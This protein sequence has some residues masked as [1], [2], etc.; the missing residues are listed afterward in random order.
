MS[1]VKLNLLDAD[2]ILSGTIHGSMTDRCVAALSAEP[3]T[4][5]ELAAALARYVR[6]AD[7][8]S[9]FVSFCAQ[10]EVD[11][12]PWDAGLVIID[13]AA[14]VISAES[15]YSQPSP[16]GEVRYHDGSKCTD[17]SIPYRVP[18]DWLFVNSFEAF[19]W[20][21]ERRRIE[22]KANPP[23]DVR[24]VL[25][26]SPLLRFV[27]DS[28]FQRRRQASPR[29][30][31]EEAHQ[32][33]ANEISR[34][35]ADWLMTS[36]EDLRDK[37]PREVILEKQD[38]IDFD[39]HTR[40]LQWTFLNEGPPCLSPDSYAYRFAGFGTHEWVVYYDLVR[41]LLWKA[42]ELECENV[43]TAMT[44]LEQIK[45]DWLEHGDDQYEKR[46]PANIL[47]S[48]RRRLPQVASAAELMIDEDCECCRMLARDAEMGFGPTFWHLDGCNMED[49]FAFSPYLTLQEWEAENRR[50]EEFDLEFERKREERRQHTSLGEEVDAELFETFGSDPF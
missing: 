37:S 24:A 41:H 34:I 50:R 3:E 10:S 46:S 36:R 39:L 33:L 1:E 18:P 40:C 32:H 25:Y 2:T 49:E 21:S 23:L 4:I 17:V 35:H 38:F 16:E 45:T 44:E 27:V 12:E 42:T 47:D 14:R 20:S 6:P 48:E 11:N 8:V 5:A 30:D 31:D 26:G 29:H 9:A 15:F 7:G 19:R 13:L 43:E 28:E 22:R